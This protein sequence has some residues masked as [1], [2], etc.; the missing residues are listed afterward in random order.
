MD[1]EVFD[2]LK[3]CIHD[4]MVVDIKYLKYLILRFKYS[5]FLFIYLMILF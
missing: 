2:T 4:T 1:E 3:E 5:F